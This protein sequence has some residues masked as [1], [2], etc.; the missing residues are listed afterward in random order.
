[1]NEEQLIIRLDRI[2]QRIVNLNIKSKTKLSTDLNVDDMLLKIKQ[3][4]ATTSEVDDKMKEI[5]HSK[6]TSQYEWGRASRKTL[7]LFIMF[8]T[9]LWKD[10]PLTGNYYILNS[11]VDCRGE[12][13][14]ETLKLFTSY[15]FDKGIIENRQSNELVSAYRINDVITLITKREV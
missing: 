8:V 7:E 11:I 2:M 13:D 14:D 15:L 4:E 5:R 12:I 9:S 10:A 1:M 6:F 3:T